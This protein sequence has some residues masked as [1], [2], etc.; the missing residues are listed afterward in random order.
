MTVEATQV[1]GPD[2]NEYGVL[3]RM[4]DPERFYCFSISGDGYYLVSRYG[5]GS[6][7]KLTGDWATSDAV[8][9]GAATNVLE[10][11]CQGA[12]MTFVV[13][14]VQVTQVEDSDYPRGDIGLYAGTFFEPDVE[15]RFDNL[16]VE[17]P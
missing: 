6:R 14:G 1:S 8:H 10:V 17:R 13:N 11:I 16:R 12:Q 15:V 3:V 9:L 7:E 5:G 2:N 4:K